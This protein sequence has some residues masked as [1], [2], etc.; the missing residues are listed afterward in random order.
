[1][2]VRALVWKEWREQRALVLTG[3]LLAVALPPFLLAGM[4]LM[5]RRVDL[6]GLAQVLPA[7]YGMLLWPLFAAAAG[8]GTIA[9]EVGNG[10]LGFLLSRPASRARIW[11]VKTAIALLSTAVIAVG[12]LGVAAAFRAFVGSA[13]SGSGGGIAGAPGVLVLLAAVSVVFFSVAAFLSTLLERTMTAAAG[14]VAASLAIVAAIAGIWGRLDLVPKL[15]PEWLTLEFL[16]AGLAILP[17]SLYVFARGEMLRGHGARRA[18]LLGGSVMLLV[19]ALVSLPIVWCVTRLDISQATLWDPTLSPS[20]DAVLSTASAPDGSSA[21]VWWIPTDG[22]GPQ[23]RTGRL[24]FNAVFTGSQGVAYLSQRGLLGMRSAAGTELRWQNMEGSED[25]VLDA[26]LPSYLGLSPSLRYGSGALLPSPSGDVIAVSTF[27]RIVVADR[28]GGT[29]RSIDLAGTALEGEQA[30]AWSPTGDALLLFRPRR[31]DDK[32]AVLEAYDLRSGSVRSIFRS[33]ESFFPRWAYE[34]SGSR[35]SVLLEVIGEAEN[36]LLEVDLEDGAET[37]IA[38][39]PCVLAAA[40]TEDERLVAYSTCDGG[41][42]TSRR[43]EIHLFDRQ[44]GEDRIVGSV[45]GS[46]RELFVSPAAD[47]VL[48]ARYDSDGVHAAIVGGGTTPVYIDGHWEP[49]GWTGRDQVV[50]FGRWQEPTPLVVASA[51]GKQLRSLLP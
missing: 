33:A 7:V 22:S 43:S 40:S 25:R 15:D 46:A 31:R 18:A 9:A 16:L 19:A 41:Q 2:M 26:G 42:P 37:I 12:T 38:R 35:A 39:S 4:A 17:A 28:K 3:L 29:P 44:S 47:R 8:A 30:I 13:G 6:A 45:D 34:S 32:E 48:L 10:T 23:R 49:L 27:D 14:G 50:L 21:Q 1:M 51:D 20:R 36:R 11:T 24:T 5:G